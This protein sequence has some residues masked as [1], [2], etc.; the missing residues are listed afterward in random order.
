MVRSI[1]VLI[2]MQCWLPVDASQCPHPL[3]YGVSVVAS[4]ASTSTKE[5]EHQRLWIPELFHISALYTVLYGPWNAV[6][7]A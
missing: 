4:Q 6:S 3:H 2:D 1:R 5:A 7:A